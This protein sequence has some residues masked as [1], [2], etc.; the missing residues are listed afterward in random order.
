MC[1]KRYLC[2]GT[3]ILFAFPAAEEVSLGASSL[4]HLVVPDSFFGHI[5]AYLLQFITGHFLSAY[6]ESYSSCLHG[7]KIHTTVCSTQN[8][9]TEWFV[10]N[11]T[12]GTVR[13]LAELM[14]L[15]LTSEIRSFSAVHDEGYAREA[16]VISK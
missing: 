4:G 2:V 11:H 7:R 5:L 1:T 12:P 6:T 8:S 15:F 3:V 14:G 9:S 13:M 16:K 10:K